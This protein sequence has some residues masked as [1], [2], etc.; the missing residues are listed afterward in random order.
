MK[1]IFIY[2]FILLLFINNSIFSNI[3]IPF[4]NNTIIKVACVKDSGYIEKYNEASYKGY[5]VDYLYNLGEY[6]N[7]KFDYILAE[8][9]QDCLNLIKSGKADIS[10]LQYINPKYENDFSYSKYPIKYFDTSLYTLAKNNEYFYEDFNQ[11][12][13]MVIGV[14]E[15][16]ETLDKVFE[17][18]NINNINLNLK[19]YTSESLLYKALENN[20][21]SAIITDYSFNSNI[22]LKKISEIYQEPVFIVTS[23][24]NPL[25]EIINSATNLL[26]ENNSNLMNILYDKHLDNKKALTAF[27]RKEQ[28]YINSSNII[29]VGI[30]ADTYIQSRY[31]ENTKKYE[32]IIIDYMEEISKL[33]NIEFQYIEIPNNINAEEAISQGYCDISPYSVRTN[34]TLQNPNLNTSINYIN[35][36]Q[37]LVIN[38][39]NPVSMDQIESI[40]CPK[41]YQGLINFIN[42][43]YPNWEVIKTKA[44]LILDPLLDRTVDV[45]IGNEYEIQYLLQNPKYD[46]LLSN[47]TYLFDILLSIGVNINQDPRLLSILNKSIKNI[48]SSTTEDIKLQGIL[49]NYH[50]TFYDS[51]YANS[52]LFNLII[53]LV[54][55]IILSLISFSRYQKNLNNEISLKEIE[56]NEINKNYEKANKAKTE[57]LAA[58][59]HDLRTPMNAIIGLTELSKENIDKKDL[60]TEYINKIDISSK[61]LLSLIN[62]ILD[63]SAIEDGKLNITKTPLNLKNLI[64]EITS[65]YNL[66]SQQNELTFKVNLNRIY[67][68]YLMGDYFRIKQIITNLLSN[69]FKFTPRKGT[70]LLSINE[71]SSNNEKLLLNII[72]KDTGIGIKKELQNKIFKKFVQAEKDTFNK[73]GG[74]GLGLS[75]VSNLVSLMNGSIS[76]ESNE[77]KGST[78]SVTIPLE[79]DIQKETNENSLINNNNCRILFVDSDIESIYDIHKILTQKGIFNDYSLSVNEAYGKTLVNE[80]KDIPYN[81]LIID[82]CIIEN[83]PN[84]FES[85][86]VSYFQGKDKHLIISGYDVTYL[87][88][89]LKNN[90]I[91]HYLRKP[92]FLSSIL[93]VINNLENLHS[94]NNKDYSEIT[95]ELTGLRVLLC[96]DNKINQIVGKHLIEN[97]GAT[98]TISDDG[99]ICLEKYLANGGLDYDII[100]MDIRM[101]RMNGYEATEKIRTS[102]LNNCKDIPIYAL[103]ANVTKK[104]IED[105]LKYG[106]NGHISKPIDSKKLYKILKN[107]WL[108]KN[109]EHY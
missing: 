45:A 13:N 93:Y 1:K 69:A 47:D 82:S 83:N 72:V 96:E 31:N 92:I 98:V 84:F 4:N 26:G 16:L 30:I 81:I 106:M 21:I 102:N 54:I 51:Y 36:R 27:T 87:K 86:L 35:M 20:E 57:F 61:Y 9:N 100:L 24:N 109:I 23:I 79:I 78:F 52:D 10:C 17:Y 88:N 8:N 99:S 56:L 59:S 25:I 28:E 101:P 95:H 22:K 46:R 32:G 33:S 103:T 55:A 48:N 108:Q 90:K 71:I 19:Y 64:Q 91:E 2:T 42:E 89:T 73:Y 58:M 50:Y 104:D 74:S 6:Y 97:F 12:E 41:N 76:L 94:S 14:R 37:L 62:D 75:I 85:K 68:E 77:G 49:T 18:A 29:K 67:H 7:L 65:M 53:F 66:Y 39:N 40:S 11:I 44:D 80:E 38:K 63:I 34:S 107:I 105:S 60:M 5:L 43:E 15:D 3:N 70:V